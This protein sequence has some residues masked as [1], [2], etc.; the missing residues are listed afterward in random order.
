MASTSTSSVASPPTDSVERQDRSCVI[1]DKDI[2]LTIARAPPAP[3]PPL[4][5]TSA[6][7][8]RQ[9]AGKDLLTEETIRHQQLEK[10]STSVSSPWV[11]CPAVYN[12][13]Q[14]S[15]TRSDSNLIVRDND[16]IQPAIPDSLAQ[17]QTDVHQYSC[18]G[19]CN[20]LQMPRA[21]SCT[22]LDIAERVNNELC[23]PILDSYPFRQFGKSKRR[24]QSQ[25]Y[26]TF[27]WLEYSIL[28]DA[29]GPILF[30]MPL[31]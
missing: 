11:P 24:F 9:H 26:S 28:N 4:P 17:H 29:V 31:L 22:P 14:S 13:I 2:G 6:T 12:T 16:A 21:G 18:S 23:R 30:C 15:T 19:D 5:P 8:E 27:P 20:P 1:L 25:F 10:P 7:G 3:V